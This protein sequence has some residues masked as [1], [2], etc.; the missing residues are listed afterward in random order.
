[1]LLLAVL[2][3]DTVFCPISIWGFFYSF[4]ESANPFPNTAHIM[5][6]MYIYTYIILRVREW[7]ICQ[8]R[9]IDAI[10]RIVVAVEINVIAAIAFQIA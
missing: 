7:R 8:K 6:Y 3:E 2:Q 5:G 10:I 1:M 9:Y 4:F